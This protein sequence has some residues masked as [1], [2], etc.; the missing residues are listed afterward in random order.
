MQEITNRIREQARKLL[1][2]GDI[3]VII[4]YQQGWD[5]ADRQPHAL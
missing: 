5:D 3:D 2:D 4:G 1:Q